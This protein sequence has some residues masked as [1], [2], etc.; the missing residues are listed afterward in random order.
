MEGES[1]E[2]GGDAAVVLV[3]DGLFAL[4]AATV[5]ETDG[6]DDESSWTPLPTLLIPGL[7][8]NKVE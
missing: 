3:G 6:V 1:T 8:V 2:E 4:S 7:V 5:A